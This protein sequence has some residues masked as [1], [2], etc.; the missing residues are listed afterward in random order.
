M[1]RF[2]NGGSD[3]AGGAD[4]AGLNRRSWQ[5]GL[6]PFQNRGIRT[7][8]VLLLTLGPRA[9]LAHPGQPPAPHDLARAWLTEPAAV[10]TLLALG[11]AYAW[12]LVRLRRRA[13]PGRGVR[14]GHA[15]A[16]AL[17]WL[18][19]AAA[20]ASPLHPLGAALFSAH[21]TQHELL[22][23]V[24]APLL[25]LGRPLVAFAWAMPRVARR[26]RPPRPLGALAEPWP[27]TALHGAAVWAWHAP[28]L[29]ALALRSEAAHAAQH[30]CFLGTALLFWWAVLG[31]RRQPLGTRILVLF[32]TALHTGALGALLTFAPRP[33]VSAYLATT[34]PWG[35]TPL[36]DQALAGLVMWIP[37]GVSYL[38]AA[39]WLLAGVLRETPA[40]ASS[41]ARTARESATPSYGFSR[42]PVLGSSRSRSTSASAVYPDM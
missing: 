31:A 35:L 33:L 20:L 10:V 14:R 18:A 28:A 27:A 24:A 21:M 22:M 23:A 3:A 42:K 9:A 26:A 39:L 16:F 1:R 15:V 11:L 4:T 29:Y 2:W 41:R 37:G 19:L 38:A 17:G 13:G 7:A 12:G 6:P 36:E 8:V 5:S 25:V 32:L 40:Q 34:G 30:A